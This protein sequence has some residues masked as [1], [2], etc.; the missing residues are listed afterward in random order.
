M[1]YAAR[2]LVRGACGHFAATGRDIS[3]S[4][5]RLGL[6][7][8]VLHLDPE[9]DLGGAAACIQTRVG[10]R[11][12]LDLGLT[13][14]GRGRVRKEVEL[15][16]LVIDGSEEGVL[17]LGCSF[18]APLTAQE[19]GDLGL[20][21]PADDEEQAS[22]RLAGAWDEDGRA[23][24]DPR[25]GEEKIE[26][27]SG[28]PV[29]A[30]HARDEQRPDRRLRA[31][32]RPEDRG[33]VAPLVGRASGF[34]DATVRVRLGEDEVRAFGAEVGD[35]TGLARALRDAYGSWPLLEILDGT[36]RLWHGSAHPCG[37]EFAG[38]G[39]RGAI[40]RLAFGRRLLP[41]ELARLV[42]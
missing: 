25:L 39:D 3:R 6:L 37:L 14:A 38:S 16:R 4:G 9:A 26:S 28:V 27:L 13:A 33:G 29:P 18:L 21:L 24:L 35:F 41:A 20:E 10:S 7:S 2:L 34:T 40:L 23:V 15:V 11:F 12:H 30:Q 22:V 42:A 17:E 36:R 31:L 1:A 5:I 32:L 8:E 19:L